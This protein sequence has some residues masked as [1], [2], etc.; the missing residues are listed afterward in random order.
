MASKDSDHED[1]SAKE[2]EARRPTRS[3]ASNAEWDGDRLEEED[4][5]TDSSLN[6]LC[7]P[8]DEDN[9]EKTRLRLRTQ[10]LIAQS[11]LRKLKEADA[12]ARTQLEDRLQE[13]QKGRKRTIEKLESLQVKRT[14]ASEMWGWKQ[15]DVVDLTADEELTVDVW[16]KR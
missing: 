9:E 1:K 13:L 10:C 2:Q 5:Q 15:C 7:Q 12:S 14:V 8:R 4:D 6:R 11:T 3:S 16:K